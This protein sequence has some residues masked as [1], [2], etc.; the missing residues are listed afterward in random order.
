MDTTQIELL[1]EPAV[2]QL[3]MYRK[4][5]KTGSRTDSCTL[6]FIVSLFTT[7]KRWRQSKCSS[8]DE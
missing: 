3:G 7:A 2:S 8:T 1:Y 4:E 5:L 6:T